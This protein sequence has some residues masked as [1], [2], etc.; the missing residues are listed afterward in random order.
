MKRSNILRSTCFAVLCAMGLGAVAAEQPAA[1]DLESLQPT[2]EQMI[3]SLQ[4]VE[5]LRLQHY[6]KLKLDDA[7]SSQ[8]FDRSE[9]HTSE[10][11]S[12]A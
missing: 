12:P 3:A 5:L 2:R 1:L 11:Q 10:L 4:T 8:I 9:E 6:N 7:L